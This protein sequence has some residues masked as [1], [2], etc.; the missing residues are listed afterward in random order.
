VSSKGYIFEKTANGWVQQHRL[1]MQQAINRPLLLA[2]SVHHKNGNKLDNRL[3]NLE[4]KG[5][6]RHTAEHHI[7]SKRTGSALDN[8]RMA[9]SRRQNTVMNKEKIK[10]ALLLKGLV[11]QSQIAYQ[12]G[13]SPMTISRLFNGKSWRFLDV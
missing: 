4:V 6:G 10:N 11:P 8:I 12:L 2:E 13:V 9:F 1:V 7:G 5:H 3:E